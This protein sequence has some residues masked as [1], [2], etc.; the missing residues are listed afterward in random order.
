M[1]GIHFVSAD[2]PKELNNPPFPVFSLSLIDLE[3]GGND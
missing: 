2:L 1:S 3:L